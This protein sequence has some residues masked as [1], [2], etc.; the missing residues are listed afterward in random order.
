MSSTRA[1]Y[2]DSN[3]AAIACT[4]CTT[5][6]ALLHVEACRRS[7]TFGGHVCYGNATHV[8][9]ETCCKAVPVRARFLDRFT[10]LEIYPKCTER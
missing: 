9:R 3:A 4:T 2:T 7:T 10:G 5:S 1:A 8:S 6:A